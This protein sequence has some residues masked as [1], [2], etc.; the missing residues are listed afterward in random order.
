MKKFLAFI[1]IFS[2]LFG[3]VSC[4][5]VGTDD[6]TGGESDTVDEI[7]SDFEEASTSKETDTK[8]REESSDTDGVGSGVTDSSVPDNTESSEEF[9]SDTEEVS[10]DEES[11]DESE[12]SSETEETEME[13]LELNAGY[14][15]VGTYDKYDLDT[16]MKP[17]WDGKVVHNETVMFVGM[18]DEVP[19]LYTP[20]KIISVRSYDLTIE[21]VDG[22][23]YALKDG[24]LVLLEGTRIPVCPLET[25]YSVHNGNPYLSTMYKGQVTQT[26]F[27]EGDTMTRWQVAVTY[28]HSDKW[29][30]VYVH[31]YDHRYD[32]LIKKLEN[33]E[34]VSIFFYGDSITAGAN[35]SNNKAPYTPPWS[36]M[37]CQ[38]I[39]KQYGYTVKYVN[40][41]SD[42][43][44]TNGTPAAGGAREDSVYGTN[45]IITYVNSA[46]GGWSTKQGLDNFPVYIK[47][48]IQK[49][50]C[51]LFVLAFG[52]NN[53][54]S[55]AETVCD[56]LKQITDKIV[57]RAPEA[58]ILLVSPM[59]PNPEAVRN[60]E[61]TFFCNGNQPTFEAEMI[62]LAEKINKSGTDCA[63]APMTSVSKYI[64]AQKRFRDSTGNNVNH[65]NDFIVRVYAQTLFQTVFGYENYPD[66]AA[67]LGDIPVVDAN[68]NGKLNDVFLD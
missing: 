58:D 22:V 34:D 40:T 21:Y 1:L 32:D 47:P 66:G 62:P 16:Y 56:L 41:A 39:A 5:A 49:Y 9:S 12:E 48:Y 43:S 18:Y 17:V 61:D 30:G 28:K 37:F 19:L 29:D 27:G 64:H 7:S 26:M 24:K 63:L 53:A 65:P 57:A 44:L 67:E 15:S 45:G 14:A 2:M 31:S 33:G 38:Y 35:A 23:D 68:Y 6:E 20:D 55:T 4:T 10:S 8:Q 11:S 25:Y 59:I 36:V 50:G 51:D 60:P 54:G 52:M 42:P 3:L 13:T 46:V